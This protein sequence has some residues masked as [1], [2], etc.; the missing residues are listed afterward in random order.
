MPYTTVPDRSRQK[1]GTPGTRALDPITPGARHRLAPRFRHRVVL[2]PLQAP[3]EMTI[4]RD[5]PG[6]ANRLP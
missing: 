3:K 1:S 5:G 2:F 6:I 4:A